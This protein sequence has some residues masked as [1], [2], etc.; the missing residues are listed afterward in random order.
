MNLMSLSLKPLIFLFSLL[1]FTNRS[2]SQDCD[3]L[4]IVVRLY[5]NAPKE[6]FLREK[7]NQQTKDKDSYHKLLENHLKDRR[8]YT[9]SI[10]KSFNTHFNWCEVYFI[11]DSLWN[12]YKVGISRPYFLDKHGSLDATISPYIDSSTIFLVRGDYDEDFQAVDLDGKRIPPPFPSFVKHSL[13]SK[14]RSLMGESMDESVER[15]KKSVKKY[16]NQ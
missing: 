4:K 13:F 11:P 16:C 14:I 12:D 3:K 9:Q 2:A 10:I 6:Q 1:F 7:A 15:Y 8:K 5:L